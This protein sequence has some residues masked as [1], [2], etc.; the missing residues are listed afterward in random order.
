VRTTELYKTH[1]AARCRTILEDEDL[2]RVGSLGWPLGQVHDL[3]HQVERIARLALADEAHFAEVWQESGE[4]V[5]E[6]VTCARKRRQ[7]THR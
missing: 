1:T 6:E 3:A 2:A 5:R 7:A 4:A